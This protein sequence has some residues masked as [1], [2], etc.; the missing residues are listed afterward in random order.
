[1]YRLCVKCCMTV[2]TFCNDKPKKKKKQNTKKKKINPVNLC[3]V[4]PLRNIDI[5]VC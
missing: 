5:G 4:K 2:F 3:S 1:M